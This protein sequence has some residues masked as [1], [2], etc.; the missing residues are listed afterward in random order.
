MSFQDSFWGPNGF[1]ELRKSVKEGQDFTKDV[2]SILHERCELE[3]SYAKSLYKLSN[4]LSKATKFAIGTTQHAWQEVAVGME[5]EAEIHKRLS[6]SLEEDVIKPMK[7]LLDSQH[8]HRKCLESGVD[9]ATK[10]LNDRRSEE[11]KTKKL[12][13]TCARENERMQ[14]QAL[15]SKVSKGK[16]LTEKDIHKLENKRRKAEETL[17]RADVDYYNSCIK[18]ERSRQ[19]H[20][21]VVYRASTAFQQLEEERLSH[22]HDFLQKYANHLSLLGPSLTQGCERL[23]VAIASVDVT[24]DLQSMV[25]MKGT[26]PNIPEQILPDFYAE[27]M[28]NEMKKE[29]RKETL[30]RFLTI[31][32]HDLELER[33]GK[34]GVENLAKVFQETPTFG[35]AEAQQDVFEKLQH[36]RAMLTYLEASRFK[37]QCAVAELE[38]SP[39][40]THPLSAHMEIKSKQGVCQTVLKIPR[41]VG[42]E[43]RNSES[44]GSAGSDVP[45]F[46]LHQEDNRDQ[47]YANV[48]A[49]LSSVKSIA[50]CQAL[51]VYEAKLSDEL[52]FNPGDIISIHEKTQDGWWHGELNGIT[53]VFPSTYVQEI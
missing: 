20:E 18:A 23:N 52:S 44:S 2:A 8:K 36:M 29:R 1:G 21:S 26:G 19:D 10:I 4:K 46:E 33:R 6:G 53:G 49:R 24:S 28:S 39:K 31:L 7:N 51:Y 27:N 35:D 32:K 5:N 16:L 9:K 12:S 13:Y 48:P 38:G 14:D 50:Q 11:L 37:L 3:I 25:E 43:R 22:M 47:V 15:D 45:D 17:A 42:M 34:Q 41:W 30:E 40:P